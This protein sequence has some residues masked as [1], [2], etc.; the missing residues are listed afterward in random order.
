MSVDTRTVD[1]LSLIGGCTYVWFVCRR[2]QVNVGLTTYRGPGQD[3][4]S[5]EGRFGEDE[6]Q[7]EALAEDEDEDED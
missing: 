3:D 2:G 6:D 5:L 1:W 7:D 4:P